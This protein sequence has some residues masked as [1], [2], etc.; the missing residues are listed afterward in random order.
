ME[1]CI[2]HVDKDGKGEGV[3]IFHNLKAWLES[4]RDPLRVSAYVQGTRSKLF[5]PN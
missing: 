3:I 1:P 5:P 2:N 4:D